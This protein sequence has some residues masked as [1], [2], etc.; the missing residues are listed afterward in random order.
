M[1]VT[2]EMSLTE[3]MTSASVLTD[4]VSTLMKETA[5]AFTSVVNA[6]NSD[7]KQ[8]NEE[9]PDVC[10]NPRYGDSNG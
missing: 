7:D 1:K 8:K 10:D 4:C 9:S 6:I 3:I 2:V 5:D